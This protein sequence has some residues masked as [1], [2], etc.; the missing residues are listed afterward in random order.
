MSKKDDIETKLIQLLKSKSVDRDTCIGIVCG[1][2]EK[3]HD[4]LI[5]WIDKNP[6]CTQC[7]I[8][9]YLEPIDEDENDK[10]EE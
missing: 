7:E 5:D 8:L 6:E 2:D 4:D 1:L 9:D 3:E 10:D